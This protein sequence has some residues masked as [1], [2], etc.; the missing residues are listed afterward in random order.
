MAS[1]KRTDRVRLHQFIDT[2]VADLERF[3]TW[4]AA[5][6]AGVLRGE[7]DAEQWPDKMTMG[8]WMEQFMSFITSK[9]G[10]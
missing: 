7:Y 4:W 1:H 6:R 3:R 5:K 10:A 8:D 9:E 2:E